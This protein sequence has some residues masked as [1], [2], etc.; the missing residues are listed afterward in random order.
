MNEDWKHTLWIAMAIIFVLLVFG[1]S[2][3]CVQHDKEL[4]AVDK[5]VEQGQS[6]VDASCAIRAL[7]DKNLRCSENEKRET[8]IK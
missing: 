4:R 1:G 2:R 8:L 5:L 3:S 7:T 6:A